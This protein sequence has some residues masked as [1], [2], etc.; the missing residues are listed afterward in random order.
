MI[1]LWHECYKK[2][3]GAAC[4]INVFGDMVLELNTLG[5]GGS[6]VKN[7]QER[8]PLWFIIMP[9][10]FLEKFWT[11]LMNILLV[12]IAYSVPIKVAFNPDENKFYIFIDQLTNIVFICDLF[13]NFIMSYEDEDMNTEVRLKLIGLRYIKSWFFIDL[14]ACIPID[15]F[16]P[17]PITSENHKLEK[18]IERLD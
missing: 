18:E 10:T 14:L 15:L 7:N 8:K 2:A 9:N 17:D 3:R 5:K 4:F 12:Y 13:V 16:I 6:E 11:Y 1:E